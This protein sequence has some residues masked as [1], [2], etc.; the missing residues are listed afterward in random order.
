MPLQLQ[1]ILTAALESTNGGP[2]ACEVL[3]TMKVVTCC[4]SINFSSVCKTAGAKSATYVA[5]HE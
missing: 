1:P 4:Y 2:V 3:R 5:T